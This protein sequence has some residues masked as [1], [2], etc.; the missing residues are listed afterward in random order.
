VCDVLT[1]CWCPC[2]DKCEYAPVAAQ[3]EE[4]VDDVAAFDSL[5]ARHT[6][7]SYYQFAMQ[8]IE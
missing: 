1:S 7:V 3:V 8:F 2:L 5:D 6:L 4:Q